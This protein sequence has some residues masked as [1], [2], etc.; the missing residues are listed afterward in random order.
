[1]ARQKGDGRGRLGGRKPGTPNNTTREM[2]ELM[3]KFAVDNYND[4]VA[5]YMG[6]ESQKERA[7]VY[8]KAVRYVLPQL[9]SVELTGEEAPRTLK[10]EL[11]EM[12]EEMSK[13]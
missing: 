11:H 8:L 7:E 1:M 3:M 5:S 10:D 12:A 4:F 9:A 13:K 6:I 2:R